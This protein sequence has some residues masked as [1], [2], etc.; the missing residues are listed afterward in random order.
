MK[1]APMRTG[2]RLPH[3]R[4]RDRDR[5]RDRGRDKMKRAPMRTGPRLPHQRD[6]DRDRDTRDHAAG[7]RSCQ[8]GR[9]RAPQGK[10]HRKQ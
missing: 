4:D 9:V 3:R 1:R 10:T 2:P 8:P 5:G 6:R 7:D